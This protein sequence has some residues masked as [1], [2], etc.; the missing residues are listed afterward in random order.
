M[1]NFAL[2]ALVAGLFLFTGCYCDHPQHG[3]GPR[4]IQKAKNPGKPH[5]VQPV[6]GRKLRH[7]GKMPVPRY[8][9]H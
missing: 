9:G 2:L 3:H 7:E 8:I 6:P 1:K 5:R 4:L